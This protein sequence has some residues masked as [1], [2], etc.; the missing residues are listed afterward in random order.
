MFE[1]L[2]RHLGEIR[3]A[4]RT[5]GALREPYDAYVPEAYAWIGDLEGAGLADRSYFA[6]LESYGVEP[7]GA[8]ER[9][10]VSAL[11]YRLVLAMLTFLWRADRMNECVMVDA[12]RSGLL[13]AL[14]RNLACLDEACVAA[15]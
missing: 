9:L 3:E 2:T 1:P 14:L 7:G 15:A 10:D 13:E 8:W 11:D 6:T 4:A 5:L 12:V